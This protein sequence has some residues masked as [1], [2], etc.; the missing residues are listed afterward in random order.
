MVLSDD[1]NAMQSAMKHL[2]RKIVLVTYLHKKLFDKAIIKHYQYEQRKWIF[3]TIEV[4]KAFFGKQKRSGSEIVRKG[5]YIVFSKGTSVFLTIIFYW[6]K[7]EVKKGIISTLVAML[8]KILNLFTLM[9]IQDNLSEN[10][11]AFF[12]SSL[13]MTGGKKQ[14]ICGTTH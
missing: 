2:E 4:K 1:L 5:F 12:C 7:L 3:T 10:I 6:E 14:W 13:R 9:S 8:N 11:K